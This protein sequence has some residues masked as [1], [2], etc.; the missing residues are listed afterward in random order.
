M[1]SIVSRRKLLLAAGAAAVTAA[2]GRETS[3]TLRF[4]VPSGTRA[5][6]VEATL[7]KDFARR[8]GV[9]P[10]IQLSG[11]GGNWQDVDGRLATAFAAGT[12][13][14]MAMVGANAV[15]TY[16]AAGL[17]QP[18]EPLMAKGDFRP[19]DY[20]KPFRRVNQYHGRTA[21]AL[22]SLGVM[23][24]SYNADAFRKAGLDPDRPPTTWSEMR[25]AAAAVVGKR[26]ALYGAL[27]SYNADSNWTFENFIGWAGG[28][29]MDTRR[30]RITFADRPGVDV[31]TY[32]RGL[33]ADKLSTPTTTLEMDDAFLRGDAAMVFGPST[34][35]VRYAEEASFDCR[36]AVVPIPDGGTRRLPPGGG[37]LVIFT[38]DKREQRAAW[39]IIQ[40]LTSAVGQ[41]EL[42]TSTGEIPVNVRATGARYLGPVIDKQRYRRPALDSVPDLAQRFQF[43]GL[44]AVQINDLLRENIYAALTGAK[45]PRQALSDAAS[46]AEAL[47]A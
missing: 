27:H 42:C 36:T 19:D 22:Y 10:E 45:A 9:H 2:C 46:R 40:A 41:T 30:R 5:Q 16:A 18:L 15:L 35:P 1:T 23:V 33:I 11:G 38:K 26:A 8:T 43:P 44:R 13:P 7:G 28:S 47:L 32:W 17:L 31:L 20:I 4:L 21:A 39:K 29:M 25:S 12:P 14:T 6:A 3:G 24:F 34:K 37:S